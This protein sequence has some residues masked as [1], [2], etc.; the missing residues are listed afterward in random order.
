[1]RSS[2]FC[3][4]AAIIAATL[5]FSQFTYAAT[6][7]L[8]QSSDTLN[9][10]RT[11]VNSS[12]TN[13]N[14]GIAWP[15]TALTNYGTTTNATTTPS[16]FKTGLFASS[17]SQFSQASTTRLTVGNLY[18][19]SAGNIQN[20][21]DDYISFDTFALRIHDSLSGTGFYAQLDPS[22]IASSNKTFTFPNQS[23]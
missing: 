20:T 6:I 5:F 8:T 3:I 10:F 23:G 7:Y 2:K 4:L 22:L 16:W 13:L 18:F 14:N 19:D 1:M 12:L 9:T 21:N 11:N 17:T 15:W